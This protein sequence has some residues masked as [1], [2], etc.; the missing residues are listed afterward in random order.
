MQKTMKA[1]RTHHRG[2]SEN[3]VYEDAPVPVPGP[4]DVLVEVG[5]A[6]ITFHEFEWPETW[7]D[8]NGKD[9]TPVIP[10][11]E[12]A[13]TVVAAGPQVASVAVGDRVFGRLSFTR[14]GAAAELVAADESDLAPAPRHLSDVEAAAAPLAALTAWQALVEHAR[15]RQGEHVVVLGATGGVGTYTVQLAKSL[16]ATVTALTRRPQDEFAASLGADAVETSGS[17]GASAALADADVVIDTVGGPGL[18]EVISGMRKGARLITLGAPLSEELTRGRDIE[19]T[20]FIVSSNREQL[21]KLSALLDQGL[22]KPVIAAT[23]P[24]DQ[25]R[26]AYEAGPGQGKPGKTVLTVKP[27]A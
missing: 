14:D 1:L 13:G 3:L 18:P 24:L 17:S 9:R 12:V 5:A 27:Q 6:A 21:E 19:A 11:H 23:Y 4:S 26:Q 8:D 2:G 10:S 15:V 7:V 22:L 16:N 20:F 25:G